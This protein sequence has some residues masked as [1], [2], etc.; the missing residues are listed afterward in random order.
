MEELKTLNDEELSSFN[1]SAMSSEIA[2][3]ERKLEGVMLNMDILRQYR[4]R[5]AEYNSR[6]QDLQ[7]I[8]EQR[9]QT[10]SEYEGLRQT[11]LTEFMEGLTKVAVMPN[12][13]WWTVWIRSVR[14][15]NSV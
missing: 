13:N 1:V 3:L 5:E 4:E 7:A 10:L 8:S 6:A 2:S 12:W 11:R 9:N 15:F 14:V